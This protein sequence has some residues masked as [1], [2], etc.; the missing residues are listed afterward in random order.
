MGKHTT[1]HSGKKYIPT[2]DQRKQILMMTGFGIRQEEMCSFLRI[3]RPTLEKH[4]RRELDTGMTEANMRVAQALYTNCTKNMSVQG[5]IWWTKTRMGWKDASEVTLNGGD[6][7]VMIVTGVVR[8]A[9]IE[10]S[11]AETSPRQIGVYTTT[12]G[13]AD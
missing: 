4:F 10:Q 13:S 3:S 2:E 8:D 6:R 9:D 5:Q 1:P 7:P 12:A 11:K